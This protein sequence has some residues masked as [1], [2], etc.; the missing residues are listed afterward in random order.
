MLRRVLLI[1]VCGCAFSTPAI[2]ATE[3]K[4]NCWDKAQTQVEMN[5]CAGEEYKAAD[6]ELN[7]VYQ[8]VL[9]KYKDDPK[10][11]AKLRAAQRAWLAYRDAEEEAKFPHADESKTTHYYGSI[12]PM[13]DAQ[14]R[15]WLTNQRV[16][17][18]REWLNG[19]EEGDACAGSV[20]TKPEP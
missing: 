16:E 9:K 20:E 19:T 14:Y 12:F 2:R 3:V 13:C 5:T 6:A 18:L 10:F 7:R 4:A 11:L 15:A 8:A 17:H 1:V